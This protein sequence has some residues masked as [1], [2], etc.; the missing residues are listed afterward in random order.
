MIR[1]TVTAC[2]IVGVN[3]VYGVLSILT[4][5]CEYNFHTN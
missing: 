5:Y 1:V 4:N 2:R 3:V